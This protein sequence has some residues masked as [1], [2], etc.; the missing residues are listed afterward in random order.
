[1]WGLFRKHH[2]LNGSFNKSADLYLIYWDD[3]LVGMNSILPLPN[4]D[5][6]H[7]VRSH[8]L[9]ILPDFQGLGIGTKVNDFFGNYFLQ[10]GYRYCM[11]TTHLRLI[12]HLSNSNQW[13]PTSNNGKNNETRS[14]HNQRFKNIMNND[15]MSKRVCGSFEFVGENYYELPH[16]DVY[17]DKFT[18]EDLSSIKN[19]LQELKKHNY[20]TVYHGDTKDTA[21]DKICQELGIV[22]I[23]MYK[24]VNGQRTLKKKFARF[25]DTNIEITIPKN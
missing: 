1:M 3:T 9:V 18:N 13:K 10:R 15:K 8:R 5:M 14:T 25:A 21:V 16:K 4:G 24:N 19:Y 11:R 22:V 2:Y 23:P 7:V 12:N 17:I 6:K 20:V